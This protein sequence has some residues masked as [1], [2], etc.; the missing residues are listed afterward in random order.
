VGTEGGGKAS[1]A[2]LLSRCRHQR[3]MDYSD[4]DWSK[5]GTSQ[6][7]SL[8]ISRLNPI[9][10]EDKDFLVTAIAYFSRTRTHFYATKEALGRAK[11]IRPAEVC[12]AL[13]TM[14]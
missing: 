11:I 3:K 14:T 8:A 5:N 4:D 9:E 13:V 12:S 6:R 2:L 10:D 7:P 1:T